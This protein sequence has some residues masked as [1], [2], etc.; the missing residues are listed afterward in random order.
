MDSRD[1]ELRKS[2][3]GGVLRLDLADVL[4]V[5]PQRPPMLLVDQVISLVPQR[6]AVGVKVVS[7]NEFGL[8]RRRVGFVF[9][10]TLG[11]EA[12]AQLAAIVLLFDSSAAAADGASPKPAYALTGIDRLEVQREIG[13]G[14][15][16]HLAVDVT[17]SADEGF[18]V[19]GS[20]TVGGESFL[21]ADFTL[22]R[23]IHER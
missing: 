1:L 21:D 14:D 10:A 7:G 3:G 5:L 17:P 6:H 9:P 20:V 13:P 12:L 18:L 4:R 16:L 2:L 22:A 15:V 8:S 23:T 19:R 11:L